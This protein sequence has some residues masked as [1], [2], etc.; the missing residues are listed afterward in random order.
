MLDGRVYLTASKR[1]GCKCRCVVWRV[2]GIIAPGYN[3]SEFLL[4]SFGGDDAHQFTAFWTRMVKTLDMIK[5]ARDGRILIKHAAAIVCV[6]ACQVRSCEPRNC[7]EQL[8]LL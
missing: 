6:D 2:H 8:K 4:D 1:I 7:F 3:A 5:L